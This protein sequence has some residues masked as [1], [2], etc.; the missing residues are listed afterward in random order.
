M[1]R[2]GI[3]KRARFFLNG[4]SE[5]NYSP[6][7]SLMVGLSSSVQLNFDAAL[8]KNSPIKW[9][10]VNSSKIAW[11]ILSFHPVEKFS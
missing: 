8:V 5:V 7:F 11:L 4:L 10:A 2:M 3:S 6:C 9:I 1:V